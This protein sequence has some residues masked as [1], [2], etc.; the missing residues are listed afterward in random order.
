MYVAYERRKMNNHVRL[1]H[2]TKVHPSRLHFILLLGQQ[3]EYNLT[4]W[5]DVCRKKLLNDL[6]Q[7]LVQMYKCTIVNDVKENAKSSFHF[8]LISCIYIIFISM[9]NRESQ[10]FLVITVF[11]KWVIMT[12]KHI[13]QNQLSIMTDCA[14]IIMELSVT[15]GILTN[16]TFLPN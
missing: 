12:S 16:F 6:L 15:T 13:S 10:I 7:K 2:N 14:C 9:E 11:R 5:L 8:H 4:G 1:K 3:T